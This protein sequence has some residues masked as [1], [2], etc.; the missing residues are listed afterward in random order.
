MTTNPRYEKYRAR[1]GKSR[2]QW[3]WRYFG[4]NGEQISRSSESYGNEADCDRSIEI[5]KASGSAP[6]VGRTAAP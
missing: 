1:K 6:V 5:M 2:K 4:D 3:A